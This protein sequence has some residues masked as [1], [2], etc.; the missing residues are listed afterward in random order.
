MSGKVYVVQGGQWGSEGKGAVAASFVKR[1]GVDVAVR[2]GGVNAGHTVWS[3]G[4]RFRLQQL[5]T[6]FVHGAQLVVGAGALVNVEILEREAKMVDA[7]LGRHRP[8]LELS[9]ALKIDFRVGVHDDRHTERAGVAG[10]TET[11]GATG[12][13]CSEALVAKIRERGSLGHPPLAGLLP[14]WLAACVCDTEEFLNR[15]YNDGQT[16]LVE[17]TQGQLL[18]LNLGPYPFVTH[19]PTQAAQWLVECGLSPTV[20][21]EVVGVYRTFPIR[22]SGRSGPMGSSET[23]WVDFLR[24]QRARRVAVGNLPDGFPTEDDIAAWSSAWA[25]AVKSS[26]VRAAWSVALG[27]LSDDRQERL[28]SSIEFTT[29][30]G[31]PRRIAHVDWLSVRQ[32][33]RQ[34]R[35]DSVA[36]TFADYL[37]GGC[38]PDDRRY[39]GR[40]LNKWFRRFQ[41]EAKVACGA[42]VPVRLVTYGPTE[43]D[44]HWVYGDPSGKLRRS[45]FCG[46]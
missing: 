40:E 29:V 41:E 24:Q 33:L 36:V 21:L 11:I 39:D 35:P 20:N 44:H 22:V 3:E 9:D 18:D 23:N 12:K 4:E 38:F 45:V 8:E 19:K 10:R 28:R 31:L 15:A 27:S 17:G 46:S 7:W 5:P 13:G 37:T 25:E 2:T 30:T 43:D 6:G 42:E 1:F 16:L 14:S 26:S 32:S 34:M